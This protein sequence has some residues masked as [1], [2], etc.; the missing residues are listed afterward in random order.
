M[1]TVA[2]APAAVRAQDRPR[3]DNFFTATL[4][5]RTD[6]YDAGQS[7]R[8]GG[9]DTMS[10]VLDVGPASAAVTGNARKAKLG[11][12]AMTDVYGARASARLTLRTTA[13]FKLLEGIGDF[14]PVELFVDGSFFEPPPGYH[15]GDGTEYGA[16]L[17]VFDGTTSAEV[18]RGGVEFWYGFRKLEPQ[19]AKRTVFIPL[20]A[21]EFPGQRRTFE[22]VFEVWAKAASGWGRT[23]RTQ[24]ASTCPPWPG[25]SGRASTAR[26]ASR[27]A[28]HGPRRTRPP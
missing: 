26:S 11:A 19:Q 6:A 24:A 27:R 14:Q 10:E 12:I 16:S 1:A 23:P 3:Y 7:L 5:G 22:F 25:T 15:P 20:P 4:S 13:R 17:S 2:A 28:P 18:V 8:V 21:A 9:Y